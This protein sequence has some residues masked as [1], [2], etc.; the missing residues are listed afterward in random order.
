LIARHLPV[1]TLGDHAEVELEINGKERAGGRAR[2]SGI[3]F[4]SAHDSSEWRH[5]LPYLAAPTTI[6]IG[7][8]HEQVLCT[9]AARATA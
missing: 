9:G 5:S 1:L 2:S 7:M 8:G 4:S 6:A 3:S